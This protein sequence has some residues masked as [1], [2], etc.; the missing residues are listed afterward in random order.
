MSN[1]ENRAAEHGSEII[2]DTDPH[3]FSV[4]NPP[5]VL[6]VLEST[7]IGTLTSGNTKNIAYYD[8]VALEPTDPDVLANLTSVTLTS[9][10]VQVIYG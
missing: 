1:I 6:R 5:I 4:T 9:G 8:G 2:N 3:Y 7:V 10:A